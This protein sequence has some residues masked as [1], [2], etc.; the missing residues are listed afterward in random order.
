MFKKFTVAAL[1]ATALLPAQTRFDYVVRND[2]FAGLG[3]DKS[4]LKRGMEACERVLA[5]NPNFAEALVWHGIALLA[6]SGQEDDPQKR[7]ALLQKGMTEMDHAVSLEPD[8]IGVR[9]PRG[10]TLRLVTPNLPPF[11]RPEELIENARSDYQRSYD[12]QK[13]H[14]DGLGTHPLGELLQGLGDLYS[15]QGKAEEAEKYY[16]IIQAK[17]KGTAYA[18]RAGEWMQ[19]KQ[20]LPPAKTGC[21]GCHAGK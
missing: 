4:A 7:L 2:I 3:G 8:N 9:I 20:P 6:E 11:L 5:E 15:R 18:E 16:A 13:D 12:L 14:L 1:A 21:V 19:T 17:L 10:A